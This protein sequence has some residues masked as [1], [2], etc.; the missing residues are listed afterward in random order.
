MFPLVRDD[1][2][3]SG[4]ALQIGH[5]YQITVVDQP[6]DEQADE[7]VWVLVSVD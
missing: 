7:L 6:V 4:P 3:G 2:L 1:V 5:T